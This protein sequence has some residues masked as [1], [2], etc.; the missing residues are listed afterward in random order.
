M[1]ALRSRIFDRGGVN[2]NR[3]MGASLICMMIIAIACTGCLGAK[4]PPVS[5]PPAP[6]VLVD[7]Y[8]AGGVAGY[9]DRLIIFDNGAA[10]VSTKAGSRTIVL[11][12]TVIAGISDLFT[13]AQFSMLQTNYPAPRGGSDLIRYSL[14][15]HG[16]TVTS[17]E[18][19]VPPSLLPV[20]DQMN[21]IVKNAGTA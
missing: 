21:T 4:T 10:V 15:Y 8:R 17:E 2:I 20:L 13:Q 9:D 18:S 6:A 12:A 3:W 7:Y 14:S 1:W 16:K 19:A 5:R 11:N